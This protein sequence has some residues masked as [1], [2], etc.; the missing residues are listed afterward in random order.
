MAV[1]K[2]QHAEL[3]KA[4]PMSEM[5]HTHMRS[6]VEVSWCD[7]SWGLIVNLWFLCERNTRRMI[8][9][10][11]KRRIKWSNLRREKYLAGL[12]KQ[13]CAI[14]PLSIASEARD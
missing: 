6:M 13:E 14:A 4:E 5:R 11:H 1:P 2:L 8:L 10:N 7:V 12:R 3:A 9:S